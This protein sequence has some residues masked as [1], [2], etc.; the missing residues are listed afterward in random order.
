MPSS[1]QNDTIPKKLK[2]GNISL[3]RICDRRTLRYAVY[4]PDRPKTGSLSESSRLD[5]NLRSH[6]ANYSASET[7]FITFS[8]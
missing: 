5:L 1:C 3:D 4:I 2:F 7:D 6:P 8:K